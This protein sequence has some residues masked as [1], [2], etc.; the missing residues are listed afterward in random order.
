MKRQACCFCC[1]S[2][3]FLL[4]WRW[5][6][7]LES[8][9]I[10]WFGLYCLCWVYFMNLKTTSQE[11]LDSSHNQKHDTGRIWRKTWASL[12]RWDTVHTSCSHPQH[13]VLFFLYTWR[14]S[15]FIRSHDW[16][17][18]LEVTH[19]LQC[20][21][22]LFSLNVGQRF[23]YI[24]QTGR[25]CSCEIRH[26]QWNNASTKHIPDSFMHDI[27]CTSKLQTETKEAFT[28]QLQRSQE[29]AGSSAL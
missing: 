5:F 10:N 9:S 14:T 1:V 7:L 27:E 3:L 29:R 16:A 17:S 28:Q 6:P 23:Q 4:L 8:I 26:D 25:L 2:C 24:Q 12:T 15:F 21:T 20:I 13:K 22:L 18:F 11:N 19:Q